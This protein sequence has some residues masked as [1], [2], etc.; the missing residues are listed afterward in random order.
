MRKISVR[1]MRK[2]EVRMKMKS[3][4]RKTR[5]KKRMFMRMRIVRTWKII[6]RR[7]REKSKGRMEKRIV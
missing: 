1:R 6:V 2:R 5:K 7:N 4:V 3:I